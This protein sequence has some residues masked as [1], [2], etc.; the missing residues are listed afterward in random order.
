MQVAAAAPKTV[1]QR[2]L[3]AAP[4]FI[5]SSAD[6]QVTLAAYALQMSL[7]AKGTFHL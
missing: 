6:D 4:L 7:E 5:L 2:K 3:K 1:L